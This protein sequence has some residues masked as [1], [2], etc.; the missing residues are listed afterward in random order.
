MQKKVYQIEKSKFLLKEDLTVEE[1]EKVQ[2]LLNTFYS[3]GENYVGENMPVEEIKQFLSLVLEPENSSVAENT[4]DFGKAKESVVLEV[5]KDFF[6]RRMRL[7]MNITGYFR[8]L[9]KE[10]G[11]QSQDLTN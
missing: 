10:F 11:M 8:N 6:L 5:I 7:A 3:A 1:S 4:V 2:K 9:M